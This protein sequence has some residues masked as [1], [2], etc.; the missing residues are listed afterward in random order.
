MQ[1]LSIEPHKHFGVPSI[2][3]QRNVAVVQHLAI[4][5]YALTDA[6]QTELW[7]AESRVG[8]V[9]NRA[10]LLCSVARANEARPS[11]MCRHIRPDARSKTQAHHHNTN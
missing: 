3:D 6:F 9:V 7:I 11:L 1:K 4:V 10:H 2:A 8:V 5:L